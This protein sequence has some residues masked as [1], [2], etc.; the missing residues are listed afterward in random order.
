VE[1]G[2]VAV[3]DLVALAEGVRAVAGQAAVGS[4]QRDSND[5]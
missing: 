2:L 5:S 4:D 3:A 1:V